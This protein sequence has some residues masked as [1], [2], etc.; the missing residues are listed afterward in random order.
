M[1]TLISSDER[2]RRDRQ[3]K[4]PEMSRGEYE[5]RAAG[6]R[7]EARRMAAEGLSQRQIAKRL[8]V[9]QATVHLALREGD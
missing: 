3:R 1:R 4:A 9:S 7:E 5:G 2:R 8:G 6:R